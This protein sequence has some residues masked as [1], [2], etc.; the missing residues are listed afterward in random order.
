MFGS[1]DMVKRI[2]QFSLIS[3]IGLLVV[4]MPVL[5]ADVTG[6][7]YKGDIVAI[8]S[9]TTT[10]DVTAVCP[11]NTQALIDGNYVTSDLLNTAIQNGGTDI[12][13]MPGVG[14]NPWCF[15][16]PN[17]GAG[18]SIPYTFYS[19]G[20][21]MQTGFPYFPAPTG[22]TTPDNNVSL[23]PANNF[24]IEQNG[25]VNTTL[26]TP[27]SS[28]YPTVSASTSNTQASNTSHTINLP[29][30][31]TAGDLLLV[32]FATPTTPTSITYPTG[33]VKLF[34][35]AMGTPTLSAAFRIA[36]GG[37]AATITV[38][39]G[40]AV[41]STHQSY[42]ITNYSG[43]PIARITV[44]SAASTNPD[45][46]SLT[47]QWGAVNSLYFALCCDSVSV[48]GYPT[49]YSSGVVNGS[50]PY[51]ASAQ[52]QLSV[53]SENPGTFTAA[54]GAWA[55]NTICVEVLQTSSVS[56]YPTV[57]NSATS[58]N[59]SGTSHTI[60]LPTSIV[61][62]KLLLVYFACT[63]ATA[64]PTITWPAGWTVLFSNAS[65]TFSATTNVLSAGFKIADGTEASTITVTTSNNQT[66]S[67]QS[68][69]IANYRGVPQ[70]GTATVATAGVNPAP[71]SLSPSWGSADNLWFVVACD[72]VSITDYPITY[73]SGRVVTGTA[74]YLASAQRTLKASAD[75]PGV[76]TAAAGNYVANTIAIQVNSQQ[77]FVYKQYAYRTYVS[78]TG[79]VTSAITNGFPV[80]AATNSG[81]DTGTTTTHTINL[82]SGITNGNLLLIFIGAYSATAQPQLV[83]GG[84]WNQFFY[85]ATGSWYDLLGIYKIADGSEGDN[86]T[87]TLTYSGSTSHQSFRITGFSGV[88]VAET[89]TTGSST[90]PDPPSLTSG[91]GAV[92]ALWFAACCDTTNVTGYPTNYSSG[93]TN[94]S[95]PYI[96]SARRNLSAASENPGV[97]TAASG[98]WCANTIAIA[99]GDSAWASVTAPVSSGVH[100][101]STA[102]DSTT[103]LLN[104]YTDSFGC[105]NGDFEIGSPPTGYT[106][107]KA[108]LSQVSTPTPV[109]GSYIMKVLTNDAGG[110]GSSYGYWSVPNY[111]AYA[112][113]TVTLGAWCYAPSSNN[114]SQTLRIQDTG[115]TWTTS[116]TIPADNVWHWTVVSRTIVASPTYVRCMF[117]SKTGTPADADDILYVDKAEFVLGSSAPSTTPVP[118]SALLSG[119][120]TVNNGYNWSFL[121]GG[122]MPYMDYQK[123][124]V[125]TALAQHITYERDTTFDD[126]TTYNNDATPTFY[127]ASSDSDV[128]A[129]FQN[130]KPINE[131]KCTTGVTEGTPEMFTEAPVAPTEFMGGAESGIE[132]LPGAAAINALLDYANIP[133]DFFWII[134]IFGFAAAAVILAYHLIRSS[135][136]WPAAVGG[137]IIAF[138]SLV[139]WGNPI[140]LWTVFIYGIRATGWLVSER[141]FG[142]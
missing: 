38:T 17:I 78:S 16:L 140:P 41:A 141:T 136:L 52:R 107:T 2:V 15:W 4:A 129:T 117:L 76:F 68:F 33:W 118:V 134:V 133:Q 8:N 40:E 87:L 102:A 120:S 119:A 1:S 81:S 56:G 135:L 69:Q 111:L 86:V 100:S 37:E 3:I 110:T 42:R 5:A 58:T 104:L 19:G 29:S 126:L 80:V 79:N 95:V 74:P 108:T 14:T 122:S 11:I 99:P 46:P 137:V 7:L 131:A 62:G 72:S 64:L 90:N 12:P 77:N 61:A 138:F 92:N 55:A 109:S 73:T 94:G 50:T 98:T 36:N 39:T 10:T 88:P 113:A 139:C 34:D 121:T 35:S 60:N 47:P 115:G 27:T 114:Q 127:T 51:L 132:H 24:Q 106:A 65:G 25:Y 26:N 128:T 89:V 103:T 124:W 22:M 67:T 30:G 49:N 59:A 48:T 82:P 71:I 83:A 93:A 96:A 75:E 20:P 123:I 70:V 130:F 57:V 18:E 44:T 63:G 23:E 142:W 101:I 54:S 97:F 125:S 105:A 45:P 116:T 28:G 6:A 32:F 43:Q 84:G 112:N 66:S 31:I 53:A 21:A 85:G 9:G 13:C 91:F